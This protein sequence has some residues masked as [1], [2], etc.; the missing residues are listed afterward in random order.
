MIIRKLLRELR[1][2]KTDKVVRFFGPEG[3][4]EDLG[5]LSYIEGADFL[6]F[7]SKEKTTITVEKLISLLQIYCDGI[8][9]YLNNSGGYQGSHNYPIARVEGGT[10]IKLMN[11]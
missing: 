5:K 9:T 8:E 4:F 2:H 10:T 1:K 6:L 3:K 11:K 7:K